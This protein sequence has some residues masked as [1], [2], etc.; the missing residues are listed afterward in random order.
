MP[1]D[2]QLQQLQHIETKLRKLLDRYAEVHQRLSSAQEEI[3][4]LETQL[5]EKDQQIKNFQNQ[6]NIV[7]IVDT[8]AGNPA[9]STELKLKLNEY[10][11]E[12]DKCIAYLRD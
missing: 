3:K 5:E 4:L 9:N 8:I 7:K 12:I 11:R 6:E 2:A 1:K 10:I